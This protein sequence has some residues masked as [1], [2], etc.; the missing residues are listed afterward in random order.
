MPNHVL[1]PIELKQSLVG[2]RVPLFRQ[3]RMAPLTIDYVGIEYFRRHPIVGPDLGLVAIHV[4]QIGMAISAIVA[5]KAVIGLRRVIHRDAGG[6]YRW[7]HA[8]GP[9]EVLAPLRRG[10]SVGLELYVSQKG[11]SI[12]APC[13]GGVNRH[14]SRPPELLRLEHVPI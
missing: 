1:V 6:K 9:F 12:E 10:G 2:E 7:G 11:V 13:P 4:D 8:G 3:Y 14:Y 5:D